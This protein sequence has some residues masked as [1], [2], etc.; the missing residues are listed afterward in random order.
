[1]KILIDVYEKQGS[2][3][4]VAGEADKGSFEPRIERFDCPVPANVFLKIRGA[5][6]MAP[7]SYGQDIKG[8]EVEL[9]TY[10]NETHD[11]FV[12]IWRA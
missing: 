10:E 1:M 12:K 9:R 2:E 8:R 5:E 11:F 4:R 3:S 7:A 6:L